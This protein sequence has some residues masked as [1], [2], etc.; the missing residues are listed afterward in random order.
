MKTAT[1]FNVI[2][3]THTFSGIYSQNRSQLN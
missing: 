2:E 3:N 1:W